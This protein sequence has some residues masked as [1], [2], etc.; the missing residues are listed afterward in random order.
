MVHTF[1]LTRSEEWKKN[2]LQFHV[3]SQVQCKA[4]CIIFCSH[5]STRSQQ[6]LHTYLVGPQSR[7]VEADPQVRRVGRSPRTAA[8]GAPPRARSQPVCAPGSTDTS[9]RAQSSARLR[10]AVAS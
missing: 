4:S 5:I 2:P 3:V 6:Q 9:A 8:T 1:L 10:A 7:R